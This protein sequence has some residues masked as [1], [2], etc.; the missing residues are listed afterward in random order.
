MESGNP[1]TLIFAS[2]LGTW[3]GAALFYVVIVGP[4]A[5]EAGPSGIGFLRTLARRHGTGPFYA[6]LALLTVA[7]GI[8][9]YVADGLYEPTN[10]GNLWMT[11]AVGLAILAL[12]RGASA[13]RLA[14]RRWVNAV[15]NVQAPS[16]NESDLATVLAKA[17]KI[18]ITT[19]IVLG[20]AL[21]SLVLARLRSAGASLDLL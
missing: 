17:R 14:E 4:A 10:A 2:L 1:Q 20:L 5:V 3:F 7:A 13:N 9:M 15:R 19:T 21:I 11:L 12:L 16:D 8:W 6:G 18:N